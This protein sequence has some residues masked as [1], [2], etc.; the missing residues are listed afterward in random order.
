[1]LNIEKQTVRARLGIGVSALAIMTVCGAMGAAQ[2]Q[3]FT[4]TTGFQTVTI[5]QAFAAQYNE[6]EVASGTKAV[7][8]PSWAQ[9]TWA[10][11][12]NTAI[13]ILS[14][15][16]ASN[17]STLN[18]C[19]NSGLAYTSTSCLNGAPAIQVDQGGT[20]VLGGQQTNGSIVGG[21]GFEDEIHADGDV[22]IQYAGPPQSWGTPTQTFVGNN[23][24]GG[25]LTL[26]PNTT[27]TFGLSWATAQTSFGPNTNIILDNSSVMTLWLPGTYTATMG[28]SLQGPGT[29]DLEAGTL[30]VNGQN[31][32]ATPFPGTVSVSPGAVLM[33]GDAAHADAV[34]G[35]PANPTANTLTIHGTAAGAPT[36]AGYGT[37]AANVV[38]TGGNVRPGGTAGTLGNLTVQT[39][40]QDPVGTLSVEVNPTSVSGLHVLGNADLG[41]TLKVTVDPGNYATRV[42]NI[43]QVDG[44]MTGDFASIAT[45]S[46]VKG[47]IAAVT[48]TANGYQV[49]TEVVQGAAAS[50]PV[51]VG[52]IV[53]ANRLNDD[54]LVGSLYDQIA[55]DSTDNEVE[56]APDKYVWGQAFGR[57]STISR[58]DVGYHTRAEGFTA[59]AEYRPTFHDAVIGLAASYSSERLKAKGNS[60]AE[61][62]T[63][64]I[65]AYGGVDLQYARIDGAV[66]YD[67]YGSSSK[68]DFGTNGVAWTNP[69]GDAYGASIQLSES[70]FNGLLTPYFRGIFTRQH[71][72]SSFE[73]GADLLNLR[74]DA[75]S[76]NTFAGDVGFRF[77]PFLSNAQ[78]RNKLLL[79]LALEHDFS[80]LGENVNGTYPV[81]NGQNW[82]SYWRGNAE[83]SL[84]VGLDYAGMITDRLEITARVNGRASLYQTSS[85]LSLGVKYRF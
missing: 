65:A 51:M 42:Y 35:D 66:F 11:G 43:V 41:G 58:E 52:H 29:L 46:T 25:N 16:G 67:T 20:L 84:L 54:Y 13:T 71:L 77:N 50:A 12:N 47:A 61:M 63:Y 68:R 34:Y 60:T 81:A 17:M 14:P 18:P 7:I 76:D 85:E 72:E 39:Y 24:F 40:K 70:M 26:E 30:V 75:I 8:V 33:I 9:A 3:T 1:M 19:Q 69:A 79:T 48:K 10:V 23:Y 56:V 55:Q 22:D 21:Y 44:T 15:G 59:G 80:G 37:I 73:T 2:A 27:A 57:Y 78:S 74:Y 36:L 82:Y 4:T 49:V 53:S 31:T 45:S 64:S 6:F 83:N 32:A 5:N 62:G 28:G 38:N